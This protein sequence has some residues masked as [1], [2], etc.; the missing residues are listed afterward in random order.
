MAREIHQREDL[1]RDARALVPRVM[2]TLQIDGRPVQLFAGFRGDALSLYF[3]EDPVFHFN[4]QGMLRRAFI[5]GRLLKAER[6]RLVALDRRRAEGQVQLTR[7]E[8]DN[9]RQQALLADLR[10][11]LHQ[12]RVA[13]GAN[14]VTL[15]GQ[16]PTDGDALTRL[17]DWLEMHDHVLV[18]ASP[19]VL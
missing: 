11:R 10:R 7:D 12:V 13:L 17:G 3:D 15:C 16:F 8:F 2:I 18:A 14:A 1:L 19:R 9:G 6:A 4:A 5:E